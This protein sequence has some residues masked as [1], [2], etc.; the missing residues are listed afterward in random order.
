MQNIRN[1][2]SDLTDTLTNLCTDLP[3]KMQ[4]GCMKI[5]AKVIPP[6]QKVLVSVANMVIKILKCTTESNVMNA[7]AVGGSK[8]QFRRD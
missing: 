6:I 1:Q 2:V 8:E 5:V 4:A 3:Q 7:A